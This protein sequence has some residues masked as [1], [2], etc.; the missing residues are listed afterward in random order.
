M[1]KNNIFAAQFHL[2]KSGLEGLKIFKECC[3]LL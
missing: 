1:K 3:K 2:D